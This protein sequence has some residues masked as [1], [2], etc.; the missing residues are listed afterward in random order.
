MPN[1]EANTETFPWV[2]LCVLGWT[3]DL[4]RVYS[5]LKAGDEVIWLLSPHICMETR[6]GFLTL[7]FKKEFPE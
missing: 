6:G 2:C 1:K 3:G 4:S 7:S 5:G